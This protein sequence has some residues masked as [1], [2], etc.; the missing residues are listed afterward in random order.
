MNTVY[1]QLGS[2]IG[3]RESFITK[4]MHKVEGDIGKIITA[5]S[6]FETTAWGNENQNNFLNSVIEIKTPFDAF[7]ILQKSQEIENNLGRKRSDKWGERTIDIDILFYNNKIINTKEL[8]I[9][10]PLIQK[11]KFVLVPLSEIAPNYK[12]PILKKNISTLLSECK[13][14]QKVLDYE[15]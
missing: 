6:I 5:S 4:S 3:E 10:H 12:H 15:I 13:D 7:T 8:T 1:I 9:P 11:R 14:T 2:N